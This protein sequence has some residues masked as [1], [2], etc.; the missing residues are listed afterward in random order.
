[1]L[2]YK[3]VNPGIHGDKSVKLFDTGVE[4]VYCLEIEREIK[5]KRERKRKS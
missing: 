2:R 4:V 1:M 3:Y 5:R